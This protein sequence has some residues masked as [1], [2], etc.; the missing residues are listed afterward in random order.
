[1][2]VVVVGDEDIGIQMETLTRSP[3]ICPNRR[4]LTVD[5]ID[6]VIKTMECRVVLRFAIEQ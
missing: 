3:L 5:K 1:M 6:D 2:P 4:K